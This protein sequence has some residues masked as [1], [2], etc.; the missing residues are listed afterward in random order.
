MKN[1]DSEKLLNLWKSGY[2]LI[3]SCF[4]FNDAEISEKYD[5]KYSGLIAKKD[6]FSK[7]LKNGKN[8]ILESIVD[9]S[10][11][12][13]DYS[14]AMEIYDLLRKEILKK[15]ANEKIIALGFRSP[16]SKNNYPEIIFAHFWPSNIKKINWDDSSLELSDIEYVNIKLV[17]ISNI[18]ETV[19]PN[20]SQKEIKLPGTEISNNPPGRPSNKNKIE[21]AFCALRDNGRIDFT[22]SFTRHI[23]LIRETVI[24][25]NDDLKDGKGLGDEVIRVHAKPMFDEYINPQKSS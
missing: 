23:N 19:T 16:I 4:V 1:T 13:V 14:D 12:M 8:N 24:L 20:N 18:S 25:N 2:S 7:R 5:K 15:L 6:E 10:K 3:D 21:E 17:D 11:T 22:A 9:F